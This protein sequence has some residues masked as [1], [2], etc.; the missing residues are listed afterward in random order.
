MQSGGYKIS[1]LELERTILEYPGVAGCC[2]VGV[3]DPTW[4]Q[5]VAAVIVPGQQFDEATLSRHFK[6][7]LSSYEVVAR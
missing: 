2:V 1:A 6:D 3:A 5:K 4:G 7:N